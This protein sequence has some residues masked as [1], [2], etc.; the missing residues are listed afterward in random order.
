MSNK[1]NSGKDEAINMPDIIFI[2]INTFAYRF[3]FHLKKSLPSLNPCNPPNI[4]IKYFI[5]NEFN[6]SLICIFHLY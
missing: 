6:I 5:N 4:I 2:K 3:G 1:V